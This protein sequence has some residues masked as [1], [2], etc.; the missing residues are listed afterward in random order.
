MTHFVRDPN[1]PRAAS[2]V[3]IGEKYAEKLEKQLSLLGYNT[4]F[5]PDNPF[6][7]PRL[8]GHADLS[9]LH[10]GGERVYLAPFLKG[11]SFAA[12]LVSLGADL[13]YPDIIQGG[14]YPEDAQ[15]NLRIA[16]KRVFYSR[17]RSANEIVEYLTKQGSFE[18]LH[19]RQG[20]SGCSTCAVDAN[21]IITSDAGIFRAAA[22]SGMD[23]LMITPGYIE[24]AGFAYGF[25]GGAAFKLSDTQMGFT[26]RLDRHPDKRRILD[27]LAS[28][29]ID[30]VYITDELIFDIGS[31]VTLTERN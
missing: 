5:V 26:G 13:R 17:G 28:R 19:S 4:V 27:F 12:R 25:I 16:G 21:S 14:V 18:L 20:Y 24:L 23:A 11:S 15:L 30:P 7:D 29:G 1:L 3:L 10:A 6:V 22:D 31:A 8:A 2:I 9:V